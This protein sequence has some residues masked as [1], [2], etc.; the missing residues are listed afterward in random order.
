MTRPTLVW[1]T[2]ASG[3]AL[4]LALPSAGFA[5]GTAGVT[6]RV[7][8]STS[9]QPISGVRVNV[10]GSAAGAMT[11]LSGRY[12][13]QGLSAGTVTL[14][15]QRIGFAQRDRE[16][17]LIEGG[18]VTADFA[19]VASAT[20]LPELVVTGYGTDTRTNLSTSVASVRSADLQGTPLAGVDAAIQGR[21]AGV[22]VVQN[23]G[24]PGVGVTVRIR[25][26]ASISASNQPLYVI[27]G[28]PMLRD[29]FSQLDVGGQ[30]VSSVTGINPDEIQTVDI[31]KDAAAAAIYG[32]RGSNG[33]IMITTKRG[34][35][36]AAK[37]T[38]NSYVGSQSVPKGSRWEL[39]NAS[40]YITYMNEAAENDGYGPG[41][42]S[43]ICG[44]DPATVGP[45]TDWQAAVFRTAPVRTFTL[46]MS[47][48]SDRVRYYV[49]GSQFQQTGVVFGS[50]YS[51]Q[52]GR[53]NVDLTASDRLQFRSSLTINREDNDRNENDNTIAGV[54]TNGIAEQP[55]VPV[56]RG[57][58]SFTTPPDDN[59]E[60]AN[61]LAIATYDFSESRSLRAIGSVEA[62]YTLRSGLTLNGRVGMDVLNLRDLRWYSPRVGGTYAESVNGES[63]I[64]NTTANRYVLEGFLGFDPSIRPD[65]ALSLLG[66]AS[67]EWNGSELDYLDGIG[68]AH[69]EFQY[70]GNAATI[71]AYDGSWTGHNLVSFFSRAN[72][73]F[74]NRYLMTASIRTDG[75]SRFGSRNRYGVF[76][77]ASF[78][79][80]LTDEPFAAAL[81]RRGDLKLRVSFGLTGNQDIFDNFAP[82]PR[83]GRANYADVP[84][85]A[86]SNFGNP[87][88]RWEGTREANVGFDVRLFGGR[89]TV[90]GDWY[91]K[92]TEDLL[93]N[94]PITSTSG[95]TTVF[96]NIGSMENRG[97]ELTI[98]TVNLTPAGRDGLRWST[99][100]NI[101]WNRNRVT[102]LFRNEPFPVGLYSVSRVE[103]GQP[104]SA[105]YTLRFLGVDPATGDA[106]F[107]DINNDGTINAD[108]RVFIG[109]PQPKYWG[110]I[111]NELSW[112][113]FDLRTFLQFTQ[114]HM[115]FNAI[116]VFARDGGYYHDNKFKDV[117]NRW[118]QPGDIT[119]EPRASYDGTSGFAG[120]ISSRYFEDGSYIRLQDVTLSYRLPAQWASAV[121]MADAR[122]YVSG[123]NLHT[124]TGYPGYSPDVNSNGSSSNTALATEFYAYPPART[125]MVGV[126][127]GW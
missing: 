86:Q 85:L 120:Q 8:D 113:G 66:G 71:S 13:L 62:I 22:Q 101:T 84:G 61:P 88:L 53:V 89:V 51:R 32:S 49:S 99:D 106:I 35:V 112:R 55:W 15:A 54:V 25:G 126:S 48:G 39:M 78:G 26:S 18:T 83:F 107:D 56:R 2:L 7:V 45:G 92:N 37:F 64:G 93:L 23:A 11:D 121:R 20:V 82:L 41:Y 124:W 90:I 47:G 117:L 46:G 74:H 77:A 33:V 27:D 81:A 52:S 94:R 31:L 75:S 73:T 14:R 24:N 69:D 59:L 91:K 98:N 16:V 44:C 9:G 119:N 115:I 21:A 4:A 12:T 70:P 102:K 76:P 105:F 60:Y 36:G 110:G 57:D 114:G 80:K 65:L 17:I 5:Q 123:R 116:S 67:V 30:D 1:S 118:Q 19:L 109:S 3:L 63:I 68:F 97:Y 95:Q 104:M 72:A 38:F 87:D 122:I 111:T 29:D 6:G 10:V 40:E 127:G 103:V 28:V 50:G 58:G 42:F 43:G 125:F 34:T 96:E 100:F 108:D 79:W